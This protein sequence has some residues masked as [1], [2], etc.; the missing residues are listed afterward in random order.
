MSVVE[1]TQ[2][3]EFPL[4]LRTLAVVHS[5]ASSNNSNIFGS[6]TN[7]FYAINHRLPDTF[8]VS[9]YSW[10]LFICRNAAEASSILLSLPRERKFEFV[11]DLTFLMK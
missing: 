8:S 1:W 9:F 2:N 10:H 11:L 4:S 7:S 6:I 5:Q 3:I